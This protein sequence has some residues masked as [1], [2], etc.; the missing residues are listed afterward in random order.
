MSFSGVNIACGYVRIIRGSAFVTTMAWH[1]TMAAPGVTNTPAR[2]PARRSPGDIESALGFEVTTDQEIWVAWGPA[3][4][5]S[6]AS[7]EED[8]AR[9]RVHAGETRTI[10][11]NRGDLLAWVAA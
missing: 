10:L 5:A 3:P 6:Q 9:I 1:R 7:G 2:A 8:T 4:D 11:C